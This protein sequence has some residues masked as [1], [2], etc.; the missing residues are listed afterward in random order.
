MEK[1]YDRLGH[2]NHCEMMFL[3]PGD[4]DEIITEA[5]VG[6]SGDRL[7]LGPSGGCPPDQTKAEMKGVN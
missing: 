5:A 3:M 2:I 6:L 1:H 7:E 4:L